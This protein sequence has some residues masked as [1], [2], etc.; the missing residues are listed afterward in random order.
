MATETVYKNNLENF[1]FPIHFSCCLLAEILLANKTFSASVIEGSAWWIQSAGYKVDTTLQNWSFHGPKTI[2]L[3]RESKN[4][5]F[6]YTCWSYLTV[7]QKLLKQRISLQ[8]TMDHVCFFTDGK[9]LAK[10]QIRSNLSRNYSEPH[11]HSMISCLSGGI[12]QT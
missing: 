2:I 12:P 7:S 4:K 10:A 6:S 8:I 11:E 3:K 9:I 1:S 5:V